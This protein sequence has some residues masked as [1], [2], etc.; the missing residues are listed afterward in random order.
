M[1]QGLPLALNAR[2][3][4]MLDKRRRIR[5]S[6]PCCLS[7]A[8]FSSHLPVLAVTLLGTIVLSLPFPQGGGL[9]VDSFHCMS[10]NACMSRELFNKHRCKEQSLAGT[11]PVC[12]D[13]L[14]E[15]KHPVKVWNCGIGGGAAAFVPCGRGRVS[16]A[17]CSFIPRM[18]TTE[19]C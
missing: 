3:R 10:C 9:G 12:N 4:A 14:F 1:S 17:G 2:Q 6:W 18:G 19:H 5:P 16:L 7:L 8:R 11:C 15:S 13:R